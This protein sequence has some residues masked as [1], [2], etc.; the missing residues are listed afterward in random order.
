MDAELLLAAIIDDNLPEDHPVTGDQM[1]DAELY[2]MD[3][4]ATKRAGGE[5]LVHWDA[6][7]D[8]Q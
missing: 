6:C 2:L 5:H 1:L 8:Y 4:L 3:A 7:T